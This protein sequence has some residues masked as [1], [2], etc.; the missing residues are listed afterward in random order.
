MDGQACARFVRDLGH[1]L[2]LTGLLT[3]AVQQE[4]DSLDVGPAG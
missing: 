1:V 3:H 4:A 2:N